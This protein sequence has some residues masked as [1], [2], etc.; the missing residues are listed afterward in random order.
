MQNG[1]DFRRT[2][3]PEGF[4]KNE[5]AAFAINHATRAAC[6]LFS[7]VVDNVAAEEFDRNMPTYPTAGLANLPYWF[8]LGLQNAIWSTLRQVMMHDEAASDKF[9]DIVWHRLC[10]VETICSTA[11]HF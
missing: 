1:F 2:G 11:L 6:Y 10:K 5:H 8:N 7:L 3:P 4:G 9:I